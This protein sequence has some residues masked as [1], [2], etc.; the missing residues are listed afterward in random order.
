MR[1]A[2]RFG[3]F[4]AAA[5]V[6]A[7]LAGIISSQAAGN[8]ADSFAVD[9]DTAGNTATALGTRDFCK[10][11]AAGESVI[12]DVTATNVPEATKMIGFTFTMTYDPAVITVSA[13]DQ[14]FLLA[15]LPGSSLYAGLSDAVPDTDGAFN[16]TGVDG[17]PI[18]ASSE[19]G[20]GV[21]ERLTLD[22]SAS[23]AAGEYPLT[24][25]PANTA[26]VDENNLGHNPDAIYNGVLAVGMACT[27]TPTPTPSPTPCSTNCPTPTPTPPAHAQG[28]VDC[29]GNVNS[30]DSLKILRHVAQLSVA[31]TEPCDNIGTGGPPLQGDVDC[32]GAVNSVDALKVLRHV[33]QLSVSQTE[34]C[35][36]IGT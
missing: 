26:H 1:F 22:I 12:I 21:L 13:E 15:S 30:V 18:P 17:G 34:P 5:A 20:S 29:N 35:A 24:L 11:V 3:P 31:Q 27:P 8:D 9:V 25:V 4:V 33:A 7:V 14:N 23:A 32:T 19:T 36:D 16:A 6:L 28:D 2:H 10:Q